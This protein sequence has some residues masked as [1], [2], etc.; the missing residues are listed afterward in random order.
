MFR[1]GGKDDIG[2]K[3]TLAP[4]KFLGKSARAAQQNVPNQANSIS[5][6]HGTY[7]EESDG[8]I[9]VIPSSTHYPSLYEG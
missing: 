9:T 3:V 6:Q 8:G 1:G 5:L 2:G 7:Q 4:G